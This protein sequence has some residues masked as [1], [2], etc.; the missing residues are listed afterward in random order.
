M[1]MDTLF[2]TD[3]TIAFDSL[4]PST[5]YQGSKRK[6]ARHIVAATSELEFDTVLDAFGGTGAVAYAMKLEGKTVT[7]NDH[8]AFN[9]QIGLALIENDATRLTDREIQAFANARQDAAAG[10]F[11]E[12]TFDNIYFT[13]SENRWLDGAVSTIA[14]M[15]DRYKKALCFF[16]L[17]QAAIAKRPY[18]LFHRANLYMRTAEVRRSFGNKASWDRSFADH[19]R[20]FAVQ[21]NRAVFAGTQP[22]Q[23]LCTDALAVPGAFD[24][25]YIDTPYISAKGIGVD[26]RDFYHFLEGLVDYARWPDRV[27]LTSK[28]RRLT[29]RPNPW[30]DP[31]KCH[32]MFT[33]LFERFET[34]HLVVSYRSDGIPSVA[35]LAALLK[36]FKGKVRIPSGP[37]YQYALSKKKDTREVLLI[38]TDA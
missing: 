20:A 7:Y 27:D 22:C 5:R 10:G 23:A 14:N 1:A 17:F 4:F 38:A 28:H 6:L 26:Y 11:I 30:C 24:L 34:S 8:L 32:A 19:V 3:R 2:G 12:R 25:V 9:R 16:A 33:R 35:E 18:N 31:N 37:Q 15:H 21:A 13:Q 29:P 36:R